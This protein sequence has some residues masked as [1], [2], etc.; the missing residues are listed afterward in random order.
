MSVLEDGGFNF[1]N[2]ANQLTRKIWVR[3]ENPNGDHKIKVTIDYADVTTQ[4]TAGADTWYVYAAGAGSYSASGETR[5][6][7]QSFLSNNAANLS[8]TT[9]TWWPEGQ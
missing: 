2:G 1:R 8:T 9:R 3:V 4:F 6:Q 5:T 7:F